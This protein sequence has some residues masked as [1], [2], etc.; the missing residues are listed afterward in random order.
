MGKFYVL[1]HEVVERISNLVVLQTQKID[2][3]SWA[4]GFGLRWKDKMVNL[5]I[6]PRLF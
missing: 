2:G 3:E 6:T 5:Q 4:R 1:Y